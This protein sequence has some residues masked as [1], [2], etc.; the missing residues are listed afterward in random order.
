MSELKTIDSEF[1]V[2]NYSD[3]APDY[4]EQGMGCG[5]EDRGIHNRYEAMGYGWDE[6]IDRVC[7]EFPETVL[8]SEALTILAERDVKIARLQE[9]LAEI[10]LGIDALS[11]E[12]EDE[13]DDGRRIPAREM[14]RQALEVIRSEI[15]ALKGGAP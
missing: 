13:D 10:E 2:V 11:D 14:K 1:E 6:A 7:S 8:L 15:K 5:L 4:H 9:A 12:D 3:Y